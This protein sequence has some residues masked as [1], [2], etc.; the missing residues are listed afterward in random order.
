MLEE[1][2]EEILF[3]IYDNRIIA[4][5]YCSVEKVASIIKWQTIAKQYGV[6]KSFRKV[7]RN[8]H[9][10]GYLDSH[11]KSFDVISLSR[12]GVEYVAGKHNAGTR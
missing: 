5:N 11:G 2:Q 12:F 1:Y 3:R 8:L 4:M 7:L 9:S 10:K 6:K